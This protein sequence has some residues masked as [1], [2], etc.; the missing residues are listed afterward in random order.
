MAV[1]SFNCNK[2]ITTSGGCALVAKN[3][4]YSEKARF[5]ATQASDSA[6]HYQHSHIGYNYRMSNVCAGIG[7]GQM[8]VL[9]ERVRQ[10]RA[11][12]ER[13]VKALDALPGISFV[14]ETAGISNNLWLNT[15]PGNATESGVLTRQNIRFAI[16][17]QNITTRPTLNTPDITPNFD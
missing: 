8:E 7:R 13:S 15:H 12:Y 6:P 9:P 10:H 11:V 1:F 2:I 16:V 17:A 3:A 14:T 5:L 4:D